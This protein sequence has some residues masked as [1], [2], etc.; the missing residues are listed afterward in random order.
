MPGPAPT[1]RYFSRLTAIAGVRAAGSRWPRLSSGR[2]TTATAAQP[3]DQLTTVEWEALWT[4]V[5]QRH[6]D[7]AGRIDFAGLEGDRRD[8]DRVVAYIAAVDPVAAPARFASATSRLAYDINAYNALAMQGVLDAGVPKRFGMLGRVWFFYLRGVTIGGRSTSLYS[9]E[10]DVIRRMGDPRVHFALNCM[11]VSCPRLP[12]AAFTT[13]GL[14]GEL[15]RAAR[16]FIGEDRNVHPDP[17]KRLV[18][19][20]AIFDF[21]TKDFF[22]WAPSLIAYVNRYRDKPVVLDYGIRFFD[23][24]WTINAQPGG[25]RATPTTE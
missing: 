8:L 18:Y 4:R 1:R 17:A 6:V 19:L 11:V 5:L 25:S 22:A 16:I 9:F 10:N 14:D 15:D 23:Y 3:A 2:A 7:E 13:A 21:Y 24:D 20:S 12:R